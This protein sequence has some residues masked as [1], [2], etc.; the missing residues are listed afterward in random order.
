LEL[1]LCGVMGVFE[2]E[3]KVTLSVDALRPVYKVI[4]LGPNTR[5]F[6]N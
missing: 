5:T 2:K 1:Q 3:K 6:D 4:E